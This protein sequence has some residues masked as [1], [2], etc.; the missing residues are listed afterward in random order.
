MKQ[1]ELLLELKLT[2]KNGMLY[3][4]LQFLQSFWEN[5]LDLKELI[6]SFFFNI[7]KIIWN[8]FRLKEQLQR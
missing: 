1:L 7:Y 8:A 3:N 2:Y 5:T 4:L 6:T